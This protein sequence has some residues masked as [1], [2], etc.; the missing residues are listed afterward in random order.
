MTSPTD[1]NIYNE[2][3]QKNRLYQF[4]SVF[5]DT[6]DKD[7]R[8]LLNR[9][10]RPTAEEAYA[11]IRREIAPGEKAEHTEIGSRVVT[12][13]ANKLSSR[14]DK[15]AKLKCSHYGNSR[16]TKE[17]IFKILRYPEWWSD[18]TKRREPRG[19]S[20]KGKVAVAVNEI[21]GSEEV[22]YQHKQ[23]EINE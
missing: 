18:P 21:E 6:Y 11:A 4:F 8:E 2:I 5:N 15:R 22:V 3:Q 13:H 16:H 10:K 14:R 7:K 17:G 19:D 12:K 20:D 1:I 23:G 9:N